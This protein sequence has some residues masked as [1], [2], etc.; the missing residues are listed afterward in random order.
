ML[1]YLVPVHSR[2]GR[3]IERVEMDN[4]VELDR[5]IPLIS[6]AGL[7]LDSEYA[8][9]VDFNDEDEDNLIAILP[10]A[11]TILKECVLS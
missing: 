6:V 1:S 9:D 8:D 2:L 10:Q 4:T 5:P 7:P 11:T 3:S